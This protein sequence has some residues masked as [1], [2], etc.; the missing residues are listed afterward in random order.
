M[1]PASIRLHCLKTVYFLPLLLLLLSSCATDEEVYYIERS[2]I[3]TTT[4]LPPNIIYERDDITYFICIDSLRGHILSLDGL[5]KQKILAQK[6]ISQKAVLLYDLPSINHEFTGTIE[7]I[8]VLSNASYLVYE[9]RHNDKHRLWKFHP[10]SKTL[11]CV[12]TYRNK[13][14][15]LKYNWGLE[16]GEQ[17]NDL[18]LSEYGVSDESI[19]TNSKDIPDSII[20]R[21]GDATIIWKSN[22]YG[23]T[24]FKWLDFK[25]FKNILP[26][27]FH[28]HGLHYDQSCHRLYVTSGDGK[29]ENN[30]S[31][32][33]L[34]WT[35]DGAQWSYRDWSNYWGK[36]NNAFTN[37]QMVSLYAAEDF[38][39]AGG[40][41][42][43][44][45]I[46]RINKTNNPN[47]M[48]LERVY[49]YDTLSH[50]LITQY[51]SRFKRLSN[52]MIATM[53]VNGDRN[54]LPRQ[55]RL[56][57]TRDGY[58]WYEI[59]R[60]KVEDGSENLYQTGIFEEWKGYLYF[61]INEKEEDIVRHR[62]IK[63]ALP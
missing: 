35:D 8:K 30:R 23:E 4:V 34:W 39:L 12:F 60:G 13:Y 38:I 37:G 5:T 57:A 62:F 27:W 61:L 50:G 15:Y 9:Q 51:T 52:G 17:E 11:K 45:C 56:I 7:F 10:D 41:D 40:D 55:T 48:Q 43:N 14:Q 33:C 20:G 46:Y 63:M 42:Y 36:K 32:K 28:I 47:E 25:Q 58:E 44:N 49:M 16:D 53:L 19:D 6:D 21:K 24:W 31:N 59:F 1:I 26:E 29:K 54:G 3:A 22:D 2:S 18:F